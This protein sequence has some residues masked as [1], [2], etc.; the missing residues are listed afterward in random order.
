MSFSVMINCSLHHAFQ[1]QGQNMHLTDF[2]V[3]LIVVAVAFWASVAAAIWTVLSM[4]R[5][6]E[7]ETKSNPFKTKYIMFGRQFKKV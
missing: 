5:S 4:N 7:G 2:L 1:D 6:S 3:P